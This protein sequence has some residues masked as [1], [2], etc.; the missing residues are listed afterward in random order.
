MPRQPPT[1]NPPRPAAPKH[2]PREAD[3]QAR[4]A[5]NT[6]SKAWMLIRQQVLV[7]D[8][9]QCQACGKL[10]AGR[11]AHV[12]HIAEDAE[13]NA[14]WDLSTLQTLCR[15]CNSRKGVRQ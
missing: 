4:R 14:G 8:G 3:R 1:F 11:E 15:P 10:V 7:R 12:D 13:T 2:K 6:G 5:L 9:Y